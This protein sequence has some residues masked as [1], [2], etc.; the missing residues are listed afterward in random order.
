MPA[1]FST[2]ISVVYYKHDFN[3]LYIELQS[4]SDTV[5]TSAALSITQLLKLNWRVSHSHE[6]ADTRVLLNVA[7][8]VQ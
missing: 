6:E 8:A 7:D 2:E 5:S 3:G 4:K 1:R